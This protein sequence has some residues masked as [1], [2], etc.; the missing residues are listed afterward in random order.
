MFHVTWSFGQLELTP[1]ELQMQ[2]YL[3]NTPPSFP[4][5]L[6]LPQAFPP[7]RLLPWVLSLSYPV[8]NQEHT[9]SGRHVRRTLEAGEGL[10]Q[11]C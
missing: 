4:I 10:L 11:R 5:T 1:Q 6:A 8:I 2:S 3:T 9:F 7:S